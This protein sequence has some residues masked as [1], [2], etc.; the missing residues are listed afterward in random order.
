[1][2]NGNSYLVWCLGRPSLNRTKSSQEA[3]EREAHS[4]ASAYPNHQ[5]DVYE[6]VASYCQE[7]P[8]GSA[9]PGGPK[10]PPNTQDF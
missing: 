3:A 2:S 1:M 4:L 5:F 9:R 8:Y 10:R 6:H 7:L